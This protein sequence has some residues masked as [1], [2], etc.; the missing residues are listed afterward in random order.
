MNKPEPT[1]EDVRRIRN[2]LT[3][4][5]VKPIHDLDTADDETQAWWCI[6]V[7]VRYARWRWGDSDIAFAAMAAVFFGVKDDQCFL[8]TRNAM[9]IK[10]MFT[11]GECMHR[12]MDRKVGDLD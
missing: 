3:K 1:E 12:P 11:A 4:K 6:Q 7:A 9:A 5:R 2:W 10:A 8:W